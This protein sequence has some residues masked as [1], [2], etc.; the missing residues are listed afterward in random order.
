VLY[1]RQCSNL[2]NVVIGHNVVGIN[3]AAFHSC[4]NIS[5]ILLPKSIVGIAPSVFVGCEKL[6]NVYYEG[7]I[8]DWSAIKFSQ[9]DSNPMKYASHFYLRNNNEWKE[10]TSIVVPEGITKIGYQFY[11]FSNITSLSLPNSITSVEYKAFEG[12]SSLEY[13]EY[14]NGLYLGNETNPYLVLMSTNTKDLVTYN[15]TST[16]RFIYDS[17]LSDCSN[18]TS[19]AIPDSVTSIGYNAFAGCD[20]LESITLSNNLKK[21]QMF[22]FSNCSSLTSI[23]LPNSV[24]ELG[25]NAFYNCSNLTNITLSHS[26]ESINFGTFSNCSSLTS[27]TIPNNVT[28]IDSNAFANCTS[29]VD[30][31]YEGTIEGWCEVGLFGYEANP[32][33]YAS[34]F[35]LKNGSNEW[36]EVTSIEIPETIT[37]IGTYQFMGFAN[38]T[39]ITIPNSVSFIDA[40]AFANCTS[41]VDVYYEGTIEDWFGISLSNIDSNP[42][43]YAENFYIK[44]SN[45]VWEEVTSIEIPKGITKI[46]SYQFN[47][48]EHITSVSISNSV[49]KIDS[50]AFVN[51]S[52]LTQ[53]ILSDSVTRIEADAFKNC[54][55]LQDVYFTGTSEAWEKIYI[56]RSNTAFLVPEAIYY[57]SETQPVESGNYWHYNNGELVK[58]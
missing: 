40:N 54:A 21:I 12:C 32:M 27:I 3:G 15:I 18:L 48:F 35:Y 10:V 43:Y 23:V 53:V 26:L 22:A 30:V 46:K 2:V 57:Y 25:S 11:G 56:H 50:N 55:N 44:N 20:S 1:K 37:K 17:A 36:E 42:M 7:T 13:N 45:G 52:D 4:S 9:P 29:L 31:Y 14:Q 28:Q 38:I 39:A 58:W 47:G 49:T 6:T 8:E 19:I 24:N 34:H 16:N 5:S 33:Y 41:L 51:C